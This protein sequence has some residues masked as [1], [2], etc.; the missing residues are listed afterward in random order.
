MQFITQLVING[1]V[2]GRTT[3]PSADAQT[4]LCV[5]PV[6]TTLGTPLRMTLRTVAN[7]AL[8]L[9]LLYETRKGR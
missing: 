8:S 2:F 1:E 6:A 7:A 4:S 3:T 9:P 5:A